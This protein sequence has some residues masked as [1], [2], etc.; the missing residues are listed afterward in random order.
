MLAKLGH[1]LDLNAQLSPTHPD[2]SDAQ[3]RKA[4]KYSEESEKL[5][6]PVGLGGR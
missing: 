2:R 3:E 4:G 6:E 5:N 1:H